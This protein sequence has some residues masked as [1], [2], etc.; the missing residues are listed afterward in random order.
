MRE[1]NVFIL[2]VCVCVCHMVRY[3][4]HSDLMEM[5]G[6]LQATKIKRAGDPSIL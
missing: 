4:L 5:V 3:R 2:Y 6:N 1:G